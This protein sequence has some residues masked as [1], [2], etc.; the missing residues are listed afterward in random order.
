MGF[1]GDAIF[2]D[3]EG[4]GMLGT[5]QYKATPH[6]INQQSFQNPVGDQSMNWNQGMQG[7]LGATTGGAPSTTA[8][9]LGGAAQF[10]GARVGPTAQAGGANV[11]PTATYGGARLDQ[12]QFQNVLGQQQQFANQQALQAQGL[13]PSVAQ[14]QAQQQANNIM[15][16]QAAMLGSQRGSSN[17]ALAQR[18]ALDA[19]AQAQNQ[20]AQQAVLGR[21]QEVLGAQQNYGNILAGM[22]S[23]TSNWAQAQAQLEQ[24]AQLQSMGALNSQNLAAAQLMQ[25]NNQFNTGAL[26]ANNLAQAQLYQQAGLA[27]QADVNQFML[28]QGQLNQQANLANMQSQLAQNQLN[29]QQYN[30]YMDYLQ[31]QNLAQYQ[32][33]MAGQQLAVQNALG[34]SGIN[35]QAYNNAA[36]SRGGMAGGAMGAIGALAMFSDINAKTNIDD[37]DEDLDEALENIYG[38]LGAK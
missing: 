30:Q 21:T 35:A 31:Q 27:N 16:Q 10:G 5:G 6:N 15:Q 13:G 7:M 2:G 19:G 38:Q 34:A 9:Q 17:P 20:A 4:P 1:V 32:G 14:V 11:G 36:Q 18:Q 24:Q 37:A 22:G 26:N 33:Q 23:Q 29:A 28:Q 8:A 12:S 25:Q 3:E